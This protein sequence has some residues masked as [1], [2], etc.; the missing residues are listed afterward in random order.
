MD[1]P[2]SRTPRGRC[3]CR[4]LAK[5]AALRLRLQRSD[6]TVRAVQEA[7]KKQRAKMEA[8]AAARAARK[9]AMRQKVEA[10]R[11]WSEEEVRMLDKGLEKFPVGVPR[12]WEQ[13]TSYVRTRTQEEILFMVKVWPPLATVLRMACYAIDL[14]GLVLEAEQICRFLSWSSGTSRCVFG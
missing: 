6:A 7:A 14:L 3:S 10:A 11:E 5:P 1:Q 8:A 4:G 12:R 9:S 13:V 2:G